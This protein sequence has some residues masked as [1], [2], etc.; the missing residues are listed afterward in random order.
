MAAQPISVLVVD[1]EPTVCEG[2]GVILS[3]AGYRVTK[4]LSGEEAIAAAGREAVDLVLLDMILP[5]I[6]GL[7]TCAALRR[8][9]PGVPVV[10]ISG[11]S[12]GERV[13]SLQRLYGVEVFLEKPFGKAELLAGV[14][15]AL[16][17][18]R[19]S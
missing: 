4:A 13:E 19:P 16:T 17:G 14:A 8:L 11:N 15:K 2:I 1:D 3:R 6:D 5:G 12:T 7:E 18:R 9:L 10:A